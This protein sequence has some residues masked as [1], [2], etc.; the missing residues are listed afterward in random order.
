M[1]IQTWKIKKCTAE[2]MSRA[3]PLLMENKRKY[4]SLSKRS[5]AISRDKPRKTDFCHKMKSRKRV[6]NIRLV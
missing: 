1:V 5:V 4:K 2:S 6:E 3:F